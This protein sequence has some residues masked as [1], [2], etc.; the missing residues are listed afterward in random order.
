MNRTALVVGASRA[1]G[2]ALAAELLK[3]D[4]DVIGTVRGEQR[5]GLHELAESASGRVTVEQ[6][7][8]T[9]PAQVTALRE[10]LAGRTLD[11]LF[12][13]AAITRGDI[14]IADVPT[15][16]F[17][18]VMVT[19]AL[20][21]MRV[22]E[23]LRSLVAPDGTIGVMSSRQGS[24][25]LNENGGQDV[26]RASKSALNQLMR[27]Y[28]A[29]YA[30]DTRTLLLINPGWVRTE[31]GGPAAPLSIEDSIPG[32]VRTIEDHSGQPG[33]RFLDYEGRVV[34]W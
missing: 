21:P 1:L 14:P 3:H 28:A 8:M 19:N 20:A 7:E 16:M 32:V 10:R 17:T 11:L 13:N 9:A 18:E 27:C 24:I 31:L 30:D 29:R 15:E 12:V 2:L 25:S 26:Y 6:L 4:W 34:P 33:L 23:S 22:V 5:T